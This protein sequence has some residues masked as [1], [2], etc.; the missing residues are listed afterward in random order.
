MLLCKSV[1]LVFFILLI[2]GA[3]YKEI[4]YAQVKKELVPYLKNNRINLDDRHPDWECV[5]NADFYQNQI[6]L[7]GEHHGIAYS[8]DALW[9]LFKQLKVKT[10]FKYYLLE[11]PF[12]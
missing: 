9:S 12:Y 6:F 2:S 3:V 7:V 1:L 10:N 8:Y 11:A 5:F 4:V